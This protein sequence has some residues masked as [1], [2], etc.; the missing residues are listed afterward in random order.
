[1]RSI[2]LCG[3]TGVGRVGCAEEGRGGGWDGE[4]GKGRVSVQCWWMGGM[5]VI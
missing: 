5:I 3:D 2:V 1:M 4:G